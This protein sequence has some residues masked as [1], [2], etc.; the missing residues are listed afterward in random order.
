M[1]FTKL[2]R[3]FACE[4]VW[5]WARSC[6]VQCVSWFLDNSA[7]PA[8]GGWCLN[9]WSDIWAGIRK[10]S[11]GGKMSQYRYVRMQVVVVLMQAKSSQSDACPQM[12]Y[13]FQAA[14]V[15]LKP[16][17]SGFCCSITLIVVFIVIDHWTVIL[18]ASAKLAQR[19]NQWIW[20]R[21]KWSPLCG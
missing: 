8:K 4:G 21:L 17:N 3:N 2:H 1:Q 5:G 16:F 13:V 6:G 14:H 12:N 9:C 18:L 19:W 15:Y 7:P 10:S 20:E 11:C